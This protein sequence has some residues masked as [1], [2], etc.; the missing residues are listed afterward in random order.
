MISMSKRFDKFGVLTCLVTVMLA[1]SS[2][3]ANDD[4]FYTIV[5][6]QGRMITVPKEP[7]DKSENST[8]NK[9]KPNNR[10]ENITEHSSKI[11]TVK[12]IN[13]NDA[14]ASTDNSI[15]EQQ[16]GKK[17]SA[18]SVQSDTVSTIAEQYTY[19][20]KNKQSADKD[21]KI[22]QNVSSDG[23]VDFANESYIDSEVFEK[24]TAQDNDDKRFFGVPNLNGGVDFI[25]KK[26]GVLSTSDVS[27]Y[28]DFQLSQ[29][30]QVL[31]KQYLMS[32]LPDQCVPRKSFSKI[33]TLS[34]ESSVNLWPRVVADKFKKIKAAEYQVPAEFVSLDN[35]ISHVNLM[36][37]K[38]KSRKE[39]YYWPL[40]VFLDKNG[41]IVSGALNFFT[42]EQQ[43]TWSTRKAL[44]GNLKIPKNANF[45]MLT[46]MSEM[47]STNDVDNISLSKS[48]SMTLHALNG[49]R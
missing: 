15:N 38:S 10:E 48:G 18:E 4:G 11:N 7:A 16:V 21:T 8:R 19:S 24:Q 25:E 33:K 22:N 49:L 2:S 12:K 47:P 41:C 3:Y 36:S 44:V 20:N 40:P 42:K 46:P 27:V 45:M 31:T 32:V 37:F 26:S 43:E 29:N 1:S 13:V 30:Y 14:I 9:P 28:K 34:E 5:D 17:L 39:A 6:A 23:L 35:K